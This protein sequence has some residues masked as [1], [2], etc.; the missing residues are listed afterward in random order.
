V[1][2][3]E[4]DR[5]RDVFPEPLVGQGKGDRLGNGGVGEE[6]LLDLARGDFSPPRLISSFRRPVRKR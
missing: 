6:G 1:A 2:R 3:A 5:R 4:D